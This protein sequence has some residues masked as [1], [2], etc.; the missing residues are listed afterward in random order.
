MIIKQYAVHRGYLLCLSAN[1]IEICKAGVKHE[2]FYFS[3]GSRDND[4]Y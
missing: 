4:Y 3:L 2:Q 1:F